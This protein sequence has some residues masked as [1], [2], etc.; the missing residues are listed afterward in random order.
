MN[1]CDGMTILLMYIKIFKFTSIFYKIRNIVP[2]ACLSKLYYSFVHPHFLYGIEVYGS[3]SKSVLNKLCKLNNKILRILLNKPIC[4]PL[5]ELYISFNVLP[6][7]VLYEMQLLILIY[8]C[9]YFGEQL[10]LLFQNYF[11]KNENLHP[12]NTRQNLNLYVSSAKCISGFKRSTNRGS[13]LW[14]DLPNHIKIKSSLHTFKK[15]LKTYFICQ[16]GQ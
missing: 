3:A 6:L 13:K 9:M 2:H 12:Y 5:H 15:K 11:V 8:K 10:P 1:L 14:N 7:P 4:T 16:I